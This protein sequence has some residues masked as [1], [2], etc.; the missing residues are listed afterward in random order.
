MVKDYH[1][2]YTKNGQL[3]QLFFWNRI[4]IDAV[5][6]K[7]IQMAYEHKTPMHIHNSSEYDSHEGSIRIDIDGPTYYS[8]NSV[9][10]VD[11]RTGKLGAYKSHY[12]K[13]GKYIVKKKTKKSAWDAPYF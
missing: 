5:R 7:A 13:S 11:P 12:T 3:K 4:G 1:I 6:K 8:K 10:L 9:R 2:T